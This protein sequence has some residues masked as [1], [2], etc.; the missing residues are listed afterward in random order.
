MALDFV[1]NAGASRRAHSQS[2]AVLQGRVPNQSGAVV[3]RAP[4]LSSKYRG[5]VSTFV[6]DLR[7]ERS[8]L[9]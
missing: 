1:A 6:T 9:V 2:T 3:L 5:S 7:D 4:N 8:R